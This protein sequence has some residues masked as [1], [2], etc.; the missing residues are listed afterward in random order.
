MKKITLLFASFLISGV[1]FGQLHFGPQIGYSASNLTLD[2]DSITNGLKNNFLVGVFVRMGKKI[3]VQPE[4]NWMTQGS[5]FKYPS[6]QGGIVP[7][8]QDIK[9]S[10]IQVP[11]NIGWR[12]IN[13]E[14]VNVRLFAGMAA[15]FLMNA[16][17]NTTSG[18]PDDYEN[19]LVPD[20]FKNVT[21]QWDAGVGVDVLMFAIDIKYMG[22]LSNVLNDFAISGSTVTS[23]S[24]LFVV[25]L[26]WKIF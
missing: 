10:T 11:V 12:I 25:T 21:W 16:N 8:E 1:M 19:A 5:V 6:I 26:G 22:G 14:V 13:L 7:L 20:D 3:Y 23:K 24:N 18:N 2:T 17:I 4:V 15:N 9:L